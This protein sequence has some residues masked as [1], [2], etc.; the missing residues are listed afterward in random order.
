MSSITTIVVEGKGRIQDVPAAMA[1]AGT[2]YGLDMGRTAT[3]LEEIAA[4]IGQGSFLK[5]F[6]DADAL[7]DV[8]E[9]EFGEPEEDEDEIRQE[10]VFYERASHHSA[11]AELPQVR[12]LLDYLVSHEADT[13]PRL[14]A[15]YRGSYKGTVWDLRV[16][17]A[18]LDDAARDGR[19]FFLWNS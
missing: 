7:F 10:L 13:A 9:D 6:V 5:Y 4:E 3:V 11:G 16:L 2:M 14:R 12:A 19:W 17:V 8:I 15:M 1:A 18:V